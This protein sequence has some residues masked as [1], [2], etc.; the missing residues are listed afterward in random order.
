MSDIIDLD[1]LQ[2]KPVTIKLGEQEI[3]IQ[4]P[5]TAD[6]LRLGVLGQQ[7]EKINEMDDAGLDKLVQDITDQLKKVI[8]EIGDRTLNMAQLLKLVEI[9]SEM[10]VPPDAKAAR[11]QGVTPN[12][13]KKTP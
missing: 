9:V 4:P 11:E 2:P 10:G 3:E 1:A 7:M 5:K 13:P 8:P 6:V 12:S